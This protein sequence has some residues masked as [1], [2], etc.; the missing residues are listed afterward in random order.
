MNIN[1]YSPL[2]VIEGQFTAILTHYFPAHQTA[3]QSVSW[4][5]APQSRGDGS[6]ILDCDPTVICS[7]GTEGVVKLTDI[8]DCI[9]RLLVRNREVPHAS[10]YSS[11]CGSFLATDVDFWVKLFQ[12]QAAS[13]GKGHLM[14][15]VGGAALVRLALDG[16]TSGD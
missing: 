10:A 16:C 2:N 15:D 9:P 12:V 11:F 13:L 3:I 6:H 1:D 4:V 8:R 7:T 14:T 5:R